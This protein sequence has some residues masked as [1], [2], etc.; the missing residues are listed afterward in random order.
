[1]TSTP[2]HHRDLPRALLEAAGRLVAR[3]GAANASLRAIAREA[4]VSHAAPYH[5]FEDRESLLA[6]VAASGFD[7]LGTAMERAAKESRARD[8]LDRMQAAGVAYVAFAVENPEI[9]RLMFGGLLTDRTRHPGLKEAADRAFGQLTGLPGGAA[10][11]GP[12]DG[13]SPVAV[14]AWSTVHGL[15]FLLIEGLLPGRVGAVD[16]GEI[17]R[18]VTRVLG[19]GLQSFAAPGSGDDAGSGEGAGSE[20][21][22]GSGAAP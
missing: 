20:E 9:Y 19:L 15:A 18:Q 14:A 10:G 16:P 1:M 6:G 12:T 3:E 22:S 2:Y 17:A 4:G 7:A 5:H 13:P 21:A 8:P 11:P